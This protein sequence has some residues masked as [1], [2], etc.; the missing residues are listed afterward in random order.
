MTDFHNTAI[1][2]DPVFP[3]H[4]RLI[5][6]WSFTRLKIVAESKAQRGSPRRRPRFPGALHT[7]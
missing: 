7:R 4:D 5:T 2:P 1:L 6:F 3:E